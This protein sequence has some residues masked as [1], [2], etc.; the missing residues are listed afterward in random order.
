MAFPKN[1]TGVSGDKGID[2]P[3]TELTEVKVDN[4]ASQAVAQPLASASVPPPPSLHVEQSAKMANTELKSSKL[5]SQLLL[6]DTKKHRPEVWLQAQKYNLSLIFEQWDFDKNGF[7]SV[8][9][10]QHGLINVKLHVHHQRLNQILLKIGGR[11]ARAGNISAKD[12]PRFVALICNDKPDKLQAIIE[13][14][15]LKIPKERMA[16]EHL[17]VT[18]KIRAKEK[19]QEQIIN[20]LEAVAEDEE[21][22]TFNPFK[23]PG[24]MLEILTFQRGIGPAVLMFFLWQLSFTCF[25][26][27]YDDFRFDRAFYYSAQAGLSVGFGALSEEYKGGLYGHKDAEEYGSDHY[28][29]SKLVTIFNVLLGSSVIGGALGYFV[30]YMLVRQGEWFRDL[31]KM[32]DKKKK[33]EALKEKKSFFGLKYISIKDWMNDNESELKLAAIVIAFLIAGILFGMLEEEWTFISS[34]YYAVTAMST[35]GLQAP[36]PDSAFSMVFTSCFV[37]VGVPLYGVCLGSFANM[38]ISKAQAKRELKSF[39]K[40]V[41]QSEFAYA[42]ALQDHAETNGKNGEVSTSAM[43]LSLEPIEFLEMELLRTGRCDMDFIQDCEKRFTE[44]DTDESG[45]VTWTEMV[46][47]NLFEQYDKSEEGTND[48]GTI[49]FEEFKECLKDLADGAKHGLI[50]H[51]S[52]LIKDDGTLDEKMAQELF[53]KCQIDSVIHHRAIAAETGEPEKEEDVIDR[54]EFSMFMKVLMEGGPEGLEKFLKLGPTKYLAEEEADNGFTEFNEQ[55]ALVDY[56][57]GASKK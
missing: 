29:W 38:L 39:E 8:K 53:D 12:F 27:W 46:A 51:D 15:A 23:N 6:V 36:N 3:V 13:K 54:K 49:D 56:D 14:I 1:H 28:D 45:T 40:V 43:S 11:N 22:D 24:L 16:F 18:K 47:Y 42:A 57:E 44:F 34:L 17:K 20:Q 19:K 25:Y 52:A 50:S 31:Q 32:E 4:P 30:D 48:D 37:L 55:E 26:H 41:K 2:A 7:L 5:E 10:L 9:E 35:G 33:I 21:V